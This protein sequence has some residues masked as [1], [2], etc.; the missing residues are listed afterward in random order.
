MVYITHTC[1][2]NKVCLQY[3]VNICITV[4]VVFVC[5]CVCVCMCVCGVCACLCVGAC[6]CVCMCMSKHMCQGSFPGSHQAWNNA[7]L[8]S[9]TRLNSG[10]GTFC[11]AEN[12]QCC[13]THALFSLL[14][15]QGGHTHSISPLTSSVLRVVN[16]PVVTCARHWS[17]E[18][19]RKRERRG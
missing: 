11:T 6:V 9:T 14:S 15:I 16:S 4:C 7:G 17:R 10:L 19:G 12:F 2:G 8:T 1:S 13:T 18:W 3:T 5:V